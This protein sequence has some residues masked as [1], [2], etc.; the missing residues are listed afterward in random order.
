[1][2]FCYIESI[3]S[4]L[5]FPHHRQSSWPL[6]MCLS[7]KWKPWCKMHETSFALLEQSIVFICLHSWL[8]L[9]KCTK[10]NDLFCVFCTLEKSH[11]K[12]TEFFLLNTKPLFTHGI[13]S[14]FI[15]LSLDDTALDEI[16]YRL[17]S[18]SHQ[19]FGRLPHTKIWLRDSKIGTL[20][21]T[22][23]SCLYADCL[24]FCLSF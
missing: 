18:P 2:H 9:Q 5:L 1:M 23:I 13:F 10:R 8:L 15:T 16:A 11:N 12:T 3:V 19:M 4:D 21:I 17:I 24:N 7:A 20:A 6:T 14:Y 22:V